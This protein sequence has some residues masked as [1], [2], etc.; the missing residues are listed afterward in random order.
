MRYLLWFTR[1]VAHRQKRPLLVW[2]FTHDA[3]GKKWGKEMR[4]PGGGI[5]GEG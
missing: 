3:T 1:H 4:F 5:L 2:S